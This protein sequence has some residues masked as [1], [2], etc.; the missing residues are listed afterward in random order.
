MSF[1]LGLNVTLDLSWRIVVTL[2]ANPHRYLGYIRDAFLYL[3][4][5]PAVGLA[6][7]IIGFIRERKSPTGIFD[8]WRLHLTVIGAFFFFW[9]ALQL[10]WTYNRYCGVTCPVDI[11]NLIP[12]VYATVAVGHILWLFAG[13]LFMLPPVFK[14]LQNKNIVSQKGGING[15]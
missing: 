13:I 14:I 6:F 5:P 4:S 1:F 12:A 7:S 2:E 15:R 10:R 9:G 11:T 8:N 3:I